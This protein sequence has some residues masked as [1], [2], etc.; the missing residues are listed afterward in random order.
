M[1]WR[2]EPLFTGR[3]VV[4]TAGGP[5]LSLSQVRAIG[6]A[7][8]KDA[9]RVI[10]IND[11]VYPCWFADVLY[12]CDLAWWTA[13]NGVPGF[14]GR[15]VTLKHQGNPVYED[16]DWLVSTGPEGLESDPGGLRT[17]GNSGYQAINLSV[18]L[19]ASRIL[20]VGFDMRGDNTSHWFGQ[21][22]ETC[23]RAMVGGFD[24]MAKHFEGLV[25]PLLA[26]GIQIVNCTP[27]SAIGAFPTGDLMTELKRTAPVD[28]KPAKP[29]DKKPVYADRQARPGS[30]YA[31][32]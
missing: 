1:Q 12:A 27:G 28:K 4:I 23:R 31:T 29:V 11:A 30:T 22:P 13:H 10:A 3:D 7:R 16:A 17:A 26:R 5:S 32:R 9:I 20:L 14:D 24:R 2:A 8:A 19:G 25:G 6:I 18:H 21:H 15:R